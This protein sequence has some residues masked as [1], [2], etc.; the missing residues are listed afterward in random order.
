MVSIIASAAGDSVQPLRVI[1][2]MLRD[3]EGNSDRDT[4][5]LIDLGTAN[6]G[7]TDTPRLDLNIAINVVML[8]KLN[9]D[10]PTA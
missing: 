2:K 1:R 9:L 4:K 6:E 8:G 7:S 10:S 5:S 3:S